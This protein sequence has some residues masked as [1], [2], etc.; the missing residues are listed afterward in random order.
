MPPRTTKQST[1]VATPVAKSTKL[2]KAEV[3][4]EFPEFKGF[5]FDG[6]TDYNRVAQVIGSRNPKY[7]WPIVNA[8]EEKSTEVPPKLGRLIAK[9]E[10]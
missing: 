5:V 9:L 3:L 8:L 4:K 2:T 6:L 1:T 7:V 10:K